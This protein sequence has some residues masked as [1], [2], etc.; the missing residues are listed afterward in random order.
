LNDILCLRSNKTD[1]LPKKGGGRGSSSAE[2]NTVQALRKKA[3]TG[4]GPFDVDRTI[5]LLPAAANSLDE[6]I[7]KMSALEPVMAARIDRHG[8]LRIRYDASIVGIRDIERLLD[9]SGVGRPSG[10]GWR[11]KSAWYRFLDGNARS[12]ALSKGGACCSRPP[13][14]WSGDRN[15]DPK[16]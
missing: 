14:L 10:T 2:S 7:R 3:V 4:K 11:F 1:A 12:N 9:E 15:I 8:R 16:E 5:P 6:A 13:T